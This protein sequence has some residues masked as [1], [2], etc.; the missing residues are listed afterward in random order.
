MKR[1]ILICLAVMLCLSACAAGNAP[2]ANLTLTPMAE[3]TPTA[4]PTA[5]PTPSAEPTPPET[6]APTPE[7]SPETP[8]QE[9]TSMRLTINGT[10]VNVVW[11][12][13]EAVSALMEAARREKLTIRTSRYGG[14]EQVG[15]L[16][17]RLPASDVQTTTEPGDIVLYSGNQIVFFF[18]SNAWA[19]TRLG[20]IEGLS[21]DELSG[22]LGGAEAVV[23]LSA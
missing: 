13:N 1:A 7:P 16:G 23:E 11:E 17:M 12:E 8:T 6:V 4:Q 9:E 3:S 14:F 2:A 20:R 19:Y 21:R 15:P 5:V 18:G 10:E 22:L